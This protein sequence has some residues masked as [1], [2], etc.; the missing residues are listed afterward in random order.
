MRHALVSM[1]LRLRATFS[2]ISDLLARSVP[3]GNFITTFYG[4]VDVSE[5]R[6]VY[7]NA[8][9]PPPLIVRANGASEALAVTGPALGFPCS[10]PF[11]E[12]YA[13]FAPGDGLVLFTDGV[14]DVG[15]SRD[16]FFDVTGIQQV[17]AQLWN[18]DAR[19]ICEGLLVPSCD[20]PAG[21]C[22]MMQPSWLRN[23]AE[24]RSD[25]CIGPH[26]RTSTCRLH[27]DLPLDWRHRRRAV[28]REEEREEIR[29]R[30]LV[31]VEQGNHRYAAVKHVDDLGKAV[32]R[33]LEEFFANYRELSGKQF[34]V[35]DVGGDRPLREIEDHESQFQQ[36]R[37]RRF[38]RRGIPLLI[39]FAVNAS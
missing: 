23:S 8:G 9:H 20:M 32:V 21:H 4:I 36:G 22:L 6:M 14:T 11:R 29:K 15:L 26:G 18:R 25:R 16:E 28:E 13:V 38:G 27:P 24:W 3:S 31:A 12:A 1:E 39:S 34:T 35:L 7:A 17:V 30:P 5:R 37:T 19:A 33:E 2:R 10:A